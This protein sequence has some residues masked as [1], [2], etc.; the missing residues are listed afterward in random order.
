MVI[1]KGAALLLFVAS[2]TSVELAAPVIRYRTGPA[3]G[4][5]IHRIVAV[6]ATCGSYNFNV[7]DTNDGLKPMGCPEAAVVGV[8]MLLR[9]ALSFRGLDVV[10]AELVNAVT[11][12]RHETT[13]TTH[14]VTTTQTHSDAEGPRTTTATT[15]DES[16]T[17]ETT[18]SMFENVTPNEQLAILGELH[19]D[20][21]LST[22]LWIGSSPG[23]VSQRRT[24][25]AQVQLLASADR[26][27]VWSR[28]CEIEVG[29]EFTSNQ[30]ALQRAAKCA[31]D[32]PDE[33]AARSVGAR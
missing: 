28:R 1:A 26:A 21:Y 7:T 5:T 14:D 10:D 20:G 9:S 29:G 27:L 18:S 2:C 11:A 4:R 16:S 13:T 23:T 15:D 8:D 17:T 33:A 22:R 24:A 3:N 6:G 31:I 30:V 12:R 32:G 25:I 19:A